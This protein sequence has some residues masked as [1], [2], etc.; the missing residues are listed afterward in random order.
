MENLK[1]IILPPKMLTIVR[2]LSPGEGSLS[3]ALTDKNVFVRIG[4]TGGCAG[5]RKCRDSQ[6]GSLRSYSRNG[7]LLHSRSGVLRE[8]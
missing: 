4:A 3:L 7:R 1:G 6:R 5:H 2:K 8:P